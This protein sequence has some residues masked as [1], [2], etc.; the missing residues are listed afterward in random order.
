MVLESSE[1]MNSTGNKSTILMWTSFDF[2]AS[3]SQEILLEKHDGTNGFILT[4]EIDKQNRI[5]RH[6][7]NEGNIVEVGTPGWKAHATFKLYSY[8]DKEQSGSYRD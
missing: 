2:N 8:L 3:S 7:D 6:E 1:S 5:E 4:S